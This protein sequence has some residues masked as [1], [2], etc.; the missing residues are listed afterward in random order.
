MQLLDIVRELEGK[1]AYERFNVLLKHLDQ[2]GIPYDIHYYPSGS[3][4]VV[5]DTNKQFVGIGAH[6]DTVNGSPGANDNASS[7]A[8]VL[9]LV[10]RY[11]A[12]PLRNL[13]CVFY[14]FDEEETGMQ[15]SK[16]YIEDNGIRQMKAY[17]N[18]EMVGMGDR[19]ALWSLNGD[20]RGKA[21]ETLERV[22][23]AKGIPCGRYDK[24]VGRYADHVPFRR[25]FLEDAFSMTL[26]SQEDLDV[27]YHYY[28]AQEFEVDKEVL[29]EIFAQAPIFRHYH[30]PTDLAVH[31]NEDS[32]KMAEDVVYETLCRL[33]E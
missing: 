25:A 5:G 28:K 6:F 23:A 21:L 15:G 31:L 2:S 3:N 16:N 9:A 19:L 24:I 10:K 33:S 7:C 14:F 12:N 1:S 8:V 18:L 26:V 11:Y 17:I 32:L 30:K 22:A 29:E 4:I 20:S 13:H 27:A